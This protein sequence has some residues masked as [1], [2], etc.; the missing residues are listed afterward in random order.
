M[1]DQFSLFSEAMVLGLLLG[2]YYDLFRALRACC[3]MRRV[4]LVFITDGLFWF[5][6]TIYCLWF[7]FYYRWG[8]IY[9]FTYIGLASGAV[10]YYF[11]L[12]PHLFGFWY[13]LMIGLVRIGLFIQQM[14]RQIQGIFAY[15]LG[16][17]KKIPGVRRIFHS[18]Y[19]KTN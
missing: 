3:R 7:I 6:A 4:L 13:K 11:L 5:T 9:T 10:A 1:P 12:S 16:R 2:A 15:P 17:V 18:I 8:E 14:G 19:R